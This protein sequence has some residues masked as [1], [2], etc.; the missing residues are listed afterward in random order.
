MGRPPRIDRAA[1][2]EAV[3]ELGFDDVT[4]K[5]VAA[6]LGVSVPG[7]YHHVS[8]KDELVK[9]AA[10]HQL[11][12]LEIPVSD[13]QDWEAWLREWGWYSY[14]SMSERPELFGLYLADDLDNDRAM[15]T[16]AAILEHLVEQGFTLAAAYEAWMAVSAVALGAAAMRIRLRTHE[17]AGTP[18]RIGLH[19]ALIARE[20]VSASALSEMDEVVPQRPTAEFERQLD[21]ML[22]AIGERIAP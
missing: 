3:I 17:A 15:D 6:H 14:R 12:G 9:L 8:G 19:Q 20:Q 11:A 13:G 5:S 10:D 18:I 1:I 22:V 2:A 4:M 7:L 21:H 16:N